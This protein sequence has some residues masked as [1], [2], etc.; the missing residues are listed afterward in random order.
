MP[1]PR[2]APLFARAEEALEAGNPDD[3]LSIAESVLKQEPEEVEALDLKA[4]ALRSLGDVEGA[5]AVYERLRRLEPNVPLWPLAQADM[6]IRE[7][8]DDRELIDLGLD[9]LETAE[10]LAGDSPDFRFEFELL[11]ATAHNQHG[12]F[13]DA[14]LHARRALAIDPQNPE[15]L[16]EQ[17]HAFFELARFD[18]ARRACE[19]LARE[20]PDDP[21]AHYYL[22]L[23]AERRGEDARSFFSKAT[24]LSPQ[25]FPPAVVLSDEAFSRA[26][27]DAIDALPP[28]VRPHL[29]NCVI[30]IQPVPSDD[31][32]R[33]GGVSPLIL[34]LYRE[35]L[36]GFGETPLSLDQLPPGEL[37]STNAR[38]IT[39]YKNNLERFARNRQELLEEIRITVMHEVGHLL[40][41]DED[42]LYE[43]GLD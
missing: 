6:V 29:E 2:Y 17:V 25:E 7:S 8:N 11:R 23:L 31:D 30:D 35:P 3:A 20:G 41:L 34:G 22:G 18:E 15:A 1:N 37:L 32:V 33:D 39:L 43:R 12:D 24:A 26:V 5:I 28:H 38:R 14:E 40:G 19:A 10:A 16:L 36:V 4:T 9:L 13:A 42:D 27:E 21:W